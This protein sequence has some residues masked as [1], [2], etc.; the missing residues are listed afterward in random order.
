MQ[1]SQLIRC[2]TI[3]EPELM[4]SP[5]PSSGIT[6]LKAIEIHTRIV[7]TTAVTDALRCTLN[8]AT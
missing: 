8:A 5:I 1:S 2:R 4:K 6:T 7:V 3:T